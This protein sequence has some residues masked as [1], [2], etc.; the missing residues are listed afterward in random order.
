M[1]DRADAVLMDL[2]SLSFERQGC[3]WELGQLLDRVPL[4]KVTL[5]VNDNTDMR[6]LRQIL[7]T[8]AQRMP[9]GSPNR[10]STAAWQLISI[11]GLSARQPNQSYHDWKRRLDQRL[12]SVQLAAW[13]LAT[14]GSARAGRTAVHSPSEVR[15]WRQSRWAWLVLLILSAVWSGYLAGHFVPFR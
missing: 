9:A 1:L 4:S 14:A 2:S 3:A 13:L 6:C 10:N 7:E 5:L 15:Y 11:G 8:A 12:D